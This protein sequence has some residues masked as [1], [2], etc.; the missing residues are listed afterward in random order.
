[1]INTFFFNM[2]AIKS[3]QS[4]ARQGAALQARQSRPA[5]RG[6]DGR[7]HCLRARPAK[8]SPPCSKDVS[9]EKAEARQ[10][11]QRQARPRPAWTKGRMRRDR[12][13]RRCWTGS[14]PTAQ[15]ADLQ[16]CDLIIEAVFENRELKAQVTQEAE[17]LLAPGGFFASNTSTLPIS[18]LAKASAAPEKFVGIHFFSPVDKMK[19]VEIIRGTA[20]GRRHRSPRL[21][22]RAGHWQAAHRG[23]RLARL[24]HQPRLWHLCDGGCGHAGRRHPALRRS[25]TPASSAACRSGPL[26][27]LDE[28]ALTLSLHV[29]DADHAQTLRPKAKPTPPRPASCWWP[30]WCSNTSARAAPGGGGFYEYPRRERRQEVPVACNSKTLFEKPD[31]ALEHH[32]PQGPPARTARRWRQPAACR[33]NVLTSV[34]RC[35]HRLDLRHRLPGLDRRRHAVHLRHGDRQPS[36][37]GRPLWPHNSEAVLP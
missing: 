24:L 17:P 29:M 21:R 26:A 10:G 9:L 19:L 25:K 30:T 12:T 8:A 7:R 31:A 32:R 28:T 35:Q 36:R 20:D 3:G 34:A 14:T 13:Q 18:G 2:N 15:V 22:L 11:L 4:R 5:G 37:R 23:Q 27:V 1:M 33:E 6:H 16:D